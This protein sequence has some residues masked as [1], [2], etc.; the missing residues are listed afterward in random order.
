MKI[1]N[2]KDSTFTKFDNEGNIR[3]D[4]YSLADSITALPVLSSSVIQLVSFTEKSNETDIEDVFSIISVESNSV[5]SKKVSLTNSFDHFYFR[6][7]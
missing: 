4:Y 6:K 1:S 3:H 7:N 5:E 2:P